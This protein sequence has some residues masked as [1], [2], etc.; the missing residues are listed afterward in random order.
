MPD[1]KDCEWLT[2]EKCRAY[3][4]EW[5]VLPVNSVRAC[6]VAI[7]EEYCRLIQPGMRVL[8]IGCGTWSPIQEHCQK[9]GVALS[10]QQGTTK[11]SHVMTQECHSFQQ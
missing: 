7:S 5:L 11:P 4:A 2:D 6:V 8:E 3:L 1:C 10:K 9:L